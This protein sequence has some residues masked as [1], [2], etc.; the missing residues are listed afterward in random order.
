MLDDMKELAGR[1]AP[2]TGGAR[3]T[4][5]CIAL[6]LA[7]E[8]CDLTMVVTKA[9]GLEKL[10]SEVRTPGRGATTHL[11]EVWGADGVSALSGETAPDLLVK[12]AGTGIMAELE[13]AG[14]MEWKRVIDVNPFGAVKTVNAF[15][16]HFK[17]SGG[18]HI[19]NAASALGIPGFPVSGAHSTSSFALVVHPKFPAGEPARHGTEVSTVCP[20]LT[21]APIFQRSDKKGYDPAKV[22]RAIKMPRFVSTTNE[23]LSK[24]IISWIKKTQRSCRI[25]GRSAR[26]TGSTGF[27]PGL[28]RALRRLSTGS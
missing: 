10:A 24:A 6:E 1:T 2:A 16:N 20:G 25:P 7:G 13:V 27:R 23:K 26:P 17:S 11:V 18:C 21:C 22:E 12:D 19:V 28:P 14:L 15:L 3:G 4:G 9:R 8:G 5:R